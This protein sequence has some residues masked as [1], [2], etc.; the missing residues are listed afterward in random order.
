MLSGFARLLSILASCLALACC[1]GGG[2]GGSGGDTSGSAG[3]KLLATPNSPAGKLPC[4]PDLCVKFG[5]PTVVAARLLAGGFLPQFLPNDGTP[6]ASYT[7]HY[8]LTGGALP[9]GMTLDAST[10]AISGTPT[11]NGYYDATIQLAVDGYSGSLG[12]H[13][14]MEVADPILVYGA[15]MIIPG[16]SPDSVLDLIS[17]YL[18]G[19]AL[20]GQRV[21]LS[22]PSSSG[23][24]L[25]PDTGSTH[26]TY[27]AIGSVPL[28]PGLALDPATGALTGTPTQAGVWIVQVQAVV[29]ASGV[30][31]TYTTYATI[32]VGVVL[33]ETR[34]QTA[35]PVQLA[36]HAPAG[37]PITT[38]L[39]F[40]AG[41]ASLPALTYDSVAQIVTLTPAAISSGAP[42][43]T[44][45]GE[46]SLSFSA[47]G[48]REGAVG[49]VEVVN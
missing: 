19:T 35:P 29:T 41:C 1:G 27:S 3:G 31:G 6:A 45:G 44:C 34:G 49:Y 28:P 43:G 8:R 15:G 42:T 37:L 18:P 38:V 40:G 30:T 22:T 4:T 11:T 26:I 16:T 14:S 20:Q 5:Y 17:F 24:T 32:P 39:E 48:T 23:E 12:T 21:V 47:P 25:T 46:L 9:Q 10:G 2:S 7:T 33:Q 13:L 36:V